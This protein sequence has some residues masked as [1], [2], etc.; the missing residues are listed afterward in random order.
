[1]AREIA[2]KVVV[3]PAIGAV[4]DAPPVIKVSDDSVD[5]TCG[6]CGTILLHAEE[7]QIRGVLLHCLNCGSYN[8][9]ES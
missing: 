5:Y 7:G 1:M 8:M 3:A 4:S 9:T 6:R 2:L